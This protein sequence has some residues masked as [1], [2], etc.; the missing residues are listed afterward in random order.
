MAR[1]SL[2]L[3]AG[4]C[5]GTAVAPA[6]EAQTIR[7]KDLAAGDSVQ[8]ERTETIT[9]TTLVVD[10][11]GEKV[12]DTTKTTVETTAFQETILQG[13]GKKPSTKLERAYTKAQLTV[14]GVTRE[15]PYQGKTLVIEKRDDR[16]TFTIKG[17]AELP[18]ADA[19]RLDQEFNRHKDG[20][21]ETRRL[22]MPKDAVKV[23]EP[24]ALDMPAVLKPLQEIGE[25]GFDAA[26]ASGTGKLIKVYKKD[27][28]TF[29]EL[30]YAVKVPLTTLGK[31]KEKLDLLD[32][33]RV[34]F[35][36]T[37]DLCI[38]GSADLETRT[39]KEDLLA[40]ARVAL[41]AGGTGEY[42]LTLSKEVRE[43]R[44]QLPKK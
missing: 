6:Q 4:L 15:L 8:I 18:A 31:D 1:W 14:G 5:L 13:D 34:H 17:G 43:A 20:K 28:K 37:H 23:N 33:S 25:L 27:G 26:K 29:G 30:H 36:V 21:A 22:L 24:W 40:T 9:A 19:Q 7:S 3:L 10:P 16:Y 2:A 11:K 32:G 39:I 41:P 44:K 12:R 42:T 38:D 35:D